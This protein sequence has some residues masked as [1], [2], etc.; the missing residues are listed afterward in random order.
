[1]LPFTYFGG[2]A[3]K[4]Y[5][6]ELNDFD[7]KYAGLVTRLEYEEL[8]SVKND[9]SEH[10]ANLV[11]L[12]EKIAESRRVLVVMSYAA[13]SDLVDAFDSFQQ[14]CTELGYECERVTEENAGDR[15]LPDILAK[16]EARRSRSST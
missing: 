15:I 13:R 6:Q 5:D 7:E 1:L 2:A 10:A 8:N 11:A 16:L 12:A 4:V 14:V 9:W 3:Q